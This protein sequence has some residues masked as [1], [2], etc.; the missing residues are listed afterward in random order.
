MDDIDL[1]DLW[2]SSLGRLLGDEMRPGPGFS[3][4]YGDDTVG[5]GPATGWRRLPDASNAARTDAAHPTVA[6]RHVSGLEV[7]RETRVIPGFDALEYTVLLEN[8]GT[9][10]L[11]TVSN[12]QTLDVSFDQAVT[13][14]VVLVS[15]GGGLMDYFFPPRTFA[16]RTDRFAPTIPHAGVR[17][18]TTEGGRSSNKDLPFFFVHNESRRAG[19]VVAFGWS[20]QWHVD[21][22]HNIPLGVLRVTGKIPDI[23]IA[24]EPGERIEGPTALVAFYEGDIADGSNLLRRLIR[25]VYTPRLAGT[26]PEPIAVFDHW[27]NVASRFDETVLKQQAAAAA[28]IHQEYF[29]LDAGWY[30]HTDGDFNSGVG[31]WE[32]VDPERL[33]NGLAPIADHVRSCGLK[34][35]L[36]FEPERVARGSALADEHPDWVLWTSDRETETSFNSRLRGPAE[37]G[38]LDLGRPEVQAWARTLIDRYIREYGIELVKL[39][40]NMDPLPYWSANDAVGRRGMTELAHVRGLYAIFDWLRERHP[41]VVFECCA[42]GGRRIDLETA[43]RFHIYTLSD[44]VVDPAIMNF[45]LFGVNY[46]LPGNYNK[47]EYTLPVAPVDDFVPRDVGFQ[48]LFGGSAGSGGRVDLWPE[49]MK[50]MARRHVDTWKRIRRYLMEDYY[51][52]TEQPRD[53]DAWVAWQFHDR[54]DQSGFVQSFRNRSMEDGRRLVLRGLKPS[55]RYA[56]TDEYGTERFEIDGSAAMTDGIEVTHDP[57]TSRVL[58]YRPIPASPL[59]SAATPLRRGLR[60]VNSVAAQERTSSQDR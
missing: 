60:R 13:D 47:L 35:G 57:M 2:T 49:S 11:P 18:L 3:F 50:A 29:I 37:H 33:P 43:R 39:D 24:L 34:F 17:S 56:F 53:L 16:I 30:A 59:G 40:F 58:T 42:S 55:A 25:D 14:E 26:R 38:L 36:W 6:V 15:S 21:V 4:T 28:E 10:V 23:E 12:L 45:H 5:T 52:L 19:I 41:D 27:W 31:N 32:Q 46:F 22:T 44:H 20:G 54:E 48:S 1:R 7:T 51:P 8:Q 9:E